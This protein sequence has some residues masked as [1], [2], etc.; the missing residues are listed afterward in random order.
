[1][2]SSVSGALIVRRQA[3]ARAKVKNS[4]ESYTD[5]MR[6]KESAAVNRQCGAR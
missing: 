4:Q 1:M 5:L 6:V 2:S 3:K